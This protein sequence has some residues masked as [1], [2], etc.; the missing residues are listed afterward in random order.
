MATLVVSALVRLSPGKYPRSGTTPGSRSAR[1]GP[2]SSSNRR[3]SESGGDDG[4]DGGDGGGGGGGGDGNGGGRP[5]MLSAVSVEPLMS[6]WSSVASVKS[7][8]EDP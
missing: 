2:V 4:G 3:C 8:V 7:I 1:L 6:A 5:M